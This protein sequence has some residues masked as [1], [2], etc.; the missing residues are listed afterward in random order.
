MS[1]SQEVTTASSREIPL[2]PITNSLT[3]NETAQALW[4]SG[5]FKDVKS[6]AQAYVKIMVGEEFGLSPFTAMTGITMIEGKLGFMAN[7]LATFVQDSPRFKYKVITQ[8]IEKCEIEFFEREDDKWESLGISEWTV[9]DSE[10]AGLIKAKSNH[11]KYPR[12]MNYNRALSAGV[13]MFCPSVTKG[14]PAYTPDEL[15]A[16]V[17]ATG[18]AVNV[19][20]PEPV[21]DA[22]ILLD[23]DKVDHLM[24]GIEILEL[25]DHD[26][27]NLLLGSIDIDALDRT[28]SIPDGHAQ[29]SEEQFDELSTVLMAKVDERDTVPVEPEEVTDVPANPEAEVDEAPI[30]EEVQS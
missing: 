30:P 29:L 24:K 2:A 18:Q 12:A 16:E 26:R 9:Q 5:Y 14:Q 11:E 20:P 15:G 6:L 7:L 17:D 13:R 28:E 19:E 1:D 25:D 27:L 3:P 23:P 10:R 8:T 21:E 22:K 4:K